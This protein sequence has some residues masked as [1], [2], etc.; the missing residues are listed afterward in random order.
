MI[1]PCFSVRA[2]ALAALVIAGLAAP[3]GAGSLD[4][5]TGFFGPGGAHRSAGGLDKH[6]RIDL[7]RG[8]FVSRNDRLLPF[9]RRGARR[10]RIVAGKD[11]DDILRFRPRRIAR[12]APS[13]YAGSG[14]STG[15]VLDEA[16]ETSVIGSYS[17]AGS[18]YE[19]DGGTYVLSGGYPVYGA[20]QTAAPAPRAKIID[21]ARAGNA[22]SY[23]H[24]VCVIRP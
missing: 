22:C 7:K 8:L 16:A 13:P 14:D 17:G 2:A 21:V 23:E 10:N 19:T 24:G 1:R 6:R 12:L 5:A 4:G 9:D 3:A 18:V 11:Y 20:P 15:V